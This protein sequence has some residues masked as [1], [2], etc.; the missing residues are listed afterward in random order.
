MLLFWLTL[1]PVTATQSPVTGPPGPGAGT[2]PPVTG[3]PADNAG[4]SSLDVGKTLGTG[5]G[6]LLIVLIGLTLLTRQRA[7]RA[8]VA[9]VASDNTKLA[10]GRV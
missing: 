6:V 1:P 10:Y 8:A 9:T 7:G 3:A 4:S 5:A 2:Q